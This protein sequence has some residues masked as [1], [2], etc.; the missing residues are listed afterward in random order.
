M[1]PQLPSN[2]S[3]PAQQQSLRRAIPTILFNCYR[4]FASNLRT[5]QFSCRPIEPTTFGECYMDA[6][7][8]SFTRA[9][10]A[11]PSDKS[12]LKSIA[13]FCS[14]GLFVAFLFIICGVDL[15]FEFF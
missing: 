4:I 12:P 3:E 1:R 8:N 2:G 9:L 15:G 14:A 6:I 11:I 10:P 13:L 7:I 5:F